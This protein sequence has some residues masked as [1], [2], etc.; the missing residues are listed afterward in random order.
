MTVSVPAGSPPAASAS[1]ISAS[2]P[3]RVDAATKTGRVDAESLRSSAARALRI[4]RCV[5]IELEVAGDDGL[6]RAERREPL[7]IGVGL[8]RDAGQRGEHRTARAPGR[9]RTAPPSA[10]TAAR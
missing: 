10:P 2:S 3:S 6:R 5:E 7:R 4:R 1:R 9:A 8:R